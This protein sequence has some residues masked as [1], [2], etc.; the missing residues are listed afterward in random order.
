MNN[1]VENFEDFQVGE[2][3]VKL[4]MLDSFKYSDQTRFMEE[5][6]RNIQSLEINKTILNQ[7]NFK[8]SGNLRVLKLSPIYFH[9]DFF[10][11]KFDQFLFVIE[12]LATNRILTEFQLGTR[13]GNLKT[14]IFN[15]RIYEKE[16]MLSTQKLGSALK[17]VFW[18]NST[19][20]KMVIQYKHANFDGSLAIASSLIESVQRGVSAI[21]SFNFF[22]IR[23]YIAN[24][25]L[26][27]IGLYEH[28]DFFDAP[29]HDPLYCAVVVALVLK[30][31]NQYDSFSFPKQKE[32][33]AY[34]EHKVR[35]N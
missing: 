9:C 28:L 22:P 35:L 11:I 25:H 23:E 8:L 19:L 30:C 32:A 13:H 34:Y 2:N 10:E 17:K 31:P 26:R 24:P 6:T 12:S 3:L 16:R 33:Y 15:D 1:F 27:D 7:L 29:T 20:K 14:K 4:K 18:E 5:G 21:E